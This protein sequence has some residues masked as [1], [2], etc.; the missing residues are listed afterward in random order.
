MWRYDWLVRPSRQIIEESPLCFFCGDSCVEDFL[1]DKTIYGLKNNRH[2]HK[3]CL[4]KAIKTKD[5]RLEG[6]KIN[7]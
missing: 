1:Y 6:L 5:S 7:A 4:L 2:C 3:R